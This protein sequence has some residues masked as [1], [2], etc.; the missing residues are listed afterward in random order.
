[1]ADFWSQLNTMLANP[2]TQ[3]F[4]AG[5]GTQIDPEG[6]G[7]AIGV[8]TSKAIQRQQYQ[9]ATAKQQGKQD[10]LFEL[11]RRILSGTEGF[12]PAGSRGFSKMSFAPGKEGLG[13]ISAS[14]D[15]GRD[16]GSFTPS[17]NQPAN[18]VDTGTAGGTG[19]S[20]DVTSS[21]NRPQ[22]NM[23]DLFPLQ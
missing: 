6:V 10:Q 1:M 5:L 12:T 22:F 18:P 7:G 20:I 23:T 16:E 4:M 19:T 3:R 21:P 2:N 14:Y 8:P 15:V 13:E 11:A 17:I 9:K